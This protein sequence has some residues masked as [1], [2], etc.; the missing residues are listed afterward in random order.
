MR[1]RAFRRWQTDTHMRRRVK[2]DRN[3]HYD[4]L[5]CLCW[6]DAKAIA[7]FIIGA[8]D[9]FPIDGDTAVWFVSVVSGAGPRTIGETEMSYNQIA[10]R[11]VVSGQAGTGYVS[12]L[13][14][15]NYRP[16]SEIAENAAAYDAL[17]YPLLALWAAQ[18]IQSCE[19][20][21]VFD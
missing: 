7:R 3:Q 4:R 18:F 12:P 10:D 11:E 17:G 14:R 20:A 16:V 13:D 8:G 6:T 21:G 2:E 5:D 15:Q 1:S 9:T 19:A